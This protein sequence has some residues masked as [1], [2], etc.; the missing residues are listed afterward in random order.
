MPDVRQCS[1]PGCSKTHLARGLCSAHYYRWKR[2][3]DPLGGRVPPGSLQAWLADHVSYAGSECLLW[4]FA[5]NAAGYGVVYFEGRHTPAS[6]AMCRLAHGEPEAETF[7]AAHSCGRGTD[8]C[9]SPRHLRWDTPVGN[10]HD[11][12]IHGT[13]N[14]GQRNGQAKLSSS[15]VQAIRGLPKGA[16]LKQAAR[17][18]LI[19]IAQVKRI[20]NR[21]T[22][23]WLGDAK[24]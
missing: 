3:G 4:P 23:T 17:E 6:R 1:V 24:C 20:R 21:T 11:R 2:T 19:S 12:I 8:G 14:R 7:E 10:S 18:H 5:R 22:W 15:D 9:V 16:S 13:T